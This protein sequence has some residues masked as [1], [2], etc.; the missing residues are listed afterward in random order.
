[1]ASSTIELAPS[2]NPKLP[3]HLSPAFYTSSLFIL[4]LREDVRQLA[5]AFSDKYQ[6]DDEQP[7]ITP[8]ELF[9]VIWKEQSWVMFHLK[10]LEPRSRAEFLKSVHRIFIGTWLV[11]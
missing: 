11:T 2:A 6:C 5:R 1:M 7:Q 8:F 4:P 9:K 3:P 10:C